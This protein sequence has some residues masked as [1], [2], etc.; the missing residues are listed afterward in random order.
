MPDIVELNMR[1]TDRTDPQ[2]V[3][4]T[5]SGGVALSG[6]KQILS[7]LVSRWQFS[8]EF[9]IL[10]AAGARTMR[11]VKSKLMGQ[12][13]YLLLRVCDQ[14]RITAQN[15]GAEIETVP[16]SDDAPFSDDSEYAVSQPSSPIMEAAGINSPTVVVRASDL[17]EAITAGVLVSINYR[18]YQIDN[19]SVDGS[20]Y[21]LEINPPLREAVTTDD[22]VNFDAKCIWRL[23]ADDEGRTNL[24]VGKYGMVTL[25]LV[26]PV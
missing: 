26:E 5:R 14:Y 8:A 3:P 11:V 2:I 24:T 17:A 4:M 16:H 21:I 9:P 25:N 6:G 19:W 12:F 10:D 18:L 15:V 13:N 20:N 7:P 22:E 1:M 23:V